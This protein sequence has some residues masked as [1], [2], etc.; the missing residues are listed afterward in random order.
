[1]SLPQQ[2]SSRPE[3]PKQPESL[4]QLNAANEQTKKAIEQHLKDLLANPRYRG[5]DIQFEVAVDPLR[6]PLPDPAT[7]SHKKGEL[8]GEADVFTRNMDD[9]FYVEVRI[10]GRLNGQSLPEFYLGSNQSHDLSEKEIA[11][12]YVKRYLDPRLGILPEKTEAEKVLSRKYAVQ[13]EEVREEGTKARKEQALLRE[14]EVGRGRKLANRLGIKRDDLE[15]KPLVR[16]QAGKQY[17]RVLVRDKN[18]PP[19]E[20][21]VFD[22]TPASAGEDAVELSSSVAKTPLEMAKIF[23]QIDRQLDRDY[24]QETSP[25]NPKK[26][27]RKERRAGRKAQREA[28]KEEEDNVRRRFT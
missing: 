1:M 28:K 4:A 22:L 7:A 14:L 27:A 10:R 13:R 15:I 11:G 23:N 20:G 3:Q 25:A 9:P 12:V 17:V 18:K 21:V 8:G 19:E 5:A 2:P 16:K 26:E 6:V 24:P